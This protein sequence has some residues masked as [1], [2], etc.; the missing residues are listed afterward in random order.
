[1]GN[2]SAATPKLAALIN[3]EQ[4]KEGVRLSTLATLHVFTVSGC[5]K[6]T[7]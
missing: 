6:D 1:M 2:Y 7:L 3:L 4:E 5:A